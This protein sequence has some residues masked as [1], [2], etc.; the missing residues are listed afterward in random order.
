[1]TVYKAQRVVTNYLDVSTNAPKNPVNGQKW[2]DGTVMKTWD[3]IKKEWIADDLKG[4]D[5]KDT[6]IHKAWSWSADGTDRFTDKYPNENLLIRDKEVLNSIIG[7]DGGFSNFNGHSRSIHKI[8]VSNVKSLVFAQIKE[9]QTVDNTFRIGVYKS[10]GTF[11]TR[12]TSQLD[13]YIVTIPNDASFIQ[14]SYNTSNKIKVEWGSKTIYT[15]SPK[16]DYENAYPKYEGYYSSHNPV[17]STNPSDYTWSVI[18]GENGKDG[19]DGTDGPPTGIIESP[20]IPTEVYQGM[21]WKNTGNLSGFITDT[22]Y[23]YRGS[24]WEK[25]IFTA[26]NIYADNLSSITANLGTI[27]AGEILTSF[28]RGDSISSAIKKRG[29]T[30]ISDGQF[31]SSFDYVQVTNNTVLGKGDVTLDENGFMIRDLTTSNEVLRSVSYKPD[32][33]IMTDANFSYGEVNLKY[34]D[35]LNLPQISLEGINGWEKYATSGG[36]A[37]MAERNMRT[38]TLTGAFKPVTTISHTGLEQFTVCVLPIGYRPKERY[39]TVAPGSGIRL[40]LINVEPNGAVTISR[41]RDNNGYTNY[42]AGGW[43]S[44][45]CSFSAADI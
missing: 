5:G 26:D 9:S 14:M 36:S 43:Y 34:Q 23:I 22:T 44:I 39:S 38:V 33:I 15:P 28:F 30:S 4:E 18:R 37:P 25:Y 13:T 40:T 21:L 16:D 7:P 2:M 35:L 17:Q 3:E 1:M 31:R 19:T 32:K 20:T 10:D 11:V 6:Y 29:T 12:F 41:N 27:T 24:K 8:D 45:A 42:L